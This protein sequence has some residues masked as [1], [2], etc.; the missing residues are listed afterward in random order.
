M[1][2]DSTE[3]LVQMLFAEYYEE[4]GGGADYEEYGGGADSDSDSDESD[5]DY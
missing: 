2:V 3:E 5:V 4:Y 1:H